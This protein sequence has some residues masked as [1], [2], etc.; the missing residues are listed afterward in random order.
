ME[1]EILCAGSGIL[2]FQF[3][4][5]S[6]SFRFILLVVHRCQIELS[7][8]C[9]QCIYHRNK[10]SVPKPVILCK[11]TRWSTFGDFSKT[12]QVVLVDHKSFWCKAA[13]QSWQSGWSWPLCASDWLASLWHCSPVISH[14]YRRDLTDVQKVEKEMASQSAD[15][16][17]VYTESLWGQRILWDSSDPSCKK[18]KER[19][20]SGD[21][22]LQS[23]WS[24]WSACAGWIC[25][26]HCK[27]RSDRRQL[28]EVGHCQVG[29]TV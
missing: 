7:T 6:V 22:P 18:K 2:A 10:S 1:E 8:N 19:Q 23:H 13:W 20:N 14:C 12:S 21:L 26:V 27:N 3:P 25:F 29:K 17:E 11:V 4:L 5:L 15:V 9:V 28:C 16:I 24:V